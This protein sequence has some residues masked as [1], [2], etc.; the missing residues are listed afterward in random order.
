M[1]RRGSTSSSTPQEVSDYMTIA[2][3]TPF[4]AHNLL[5]AH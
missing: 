5:L 2:A 1:Y 4:M 3:T